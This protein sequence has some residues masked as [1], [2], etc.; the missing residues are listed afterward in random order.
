MS[1]P[2]SLPTTG[3]VSFVDYFEDV[4]SYS[5]QISDATAQRGRLRTVLKGLKKEALDTRDYRN[6]TIDD[7][8]PYLISIINC[9]ESGELKLHKN[10]NIETSWRS[11]LSD[12]IIHTGS[13]APRIV[14]PDIYYELIF[15]LLTYAYA[16]SLQGNDTLKAV[17]EQ[18]SDAAAIYNKVAD[19][20]NTAAGIFQYLANEILPKWR[21][22]PD[23]RPV[24]TIKELLV[25]LS[26]M[27]LADAQSIAISKALVNTGL[28]KALAAKLYMGVAEQYEMAYGL[29]SSIKGTQEVSSELRR[30]LADGS[31]FYKAMAK[32]YLA[33]DAND[34]QNLGEAVGFVRDCK[35]DLRAIQHSGLSK[36]R[37]SAVS[38]RACNE[39]EAVTELLQKLTMIND[40]VCHKK[41]RSIESVTYQTVPTRQALQQKIPSGRG[42]LEI[43]RFSPPSPLFGPVS[44]EVTGS[45]RARYARDGNYW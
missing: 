45:E 31:Q 21:Q 27:A 42:V 4:G 9:L 23:N 16:C 30:Y 11:T 7:Y 14:C 10:N 1:Y 40:T 3:A 22:P 33:L 36:T 43:K 32:K 37:R 17:Q 26:K 15:V 19:A 35:A 20:L 8:L 2:Y 34:R 38:L 25:A 6:I 29:I 13:N 39:E 44:E 12:H 24:E 41:Y 28:S 18:G 5:S